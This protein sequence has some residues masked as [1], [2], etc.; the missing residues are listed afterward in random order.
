ML[1]IIPYKLGLNYWVAFASFITFYFFLGM[2]GFYKLALKILKDK[3][4]AILAFVLL[5][6]SSLS[7]RVFDS[8]IMMILTPS[9]WFFYFG[10]VF[11]NSGQRSAFVGMVFCVML[12]L[13]TYVP[14]YFIVLVLSFLI[15]FIPI[16]WKET[17]GFFL[18]LREFVRLQKGLF[19][20]CVVATVLAC[21]PDVLFFKSAGQGIFS[22]PLRHF[23]AA[24][25]HVLIVKPDVTSYWAIPE[26]LMY[27]L[28]YLQDLRLFDFAVLYVPLFAI[29]LLLLG[30]VTSVNPKTFFILLWGLFL[31]A[32][33][34]PYLVG[35]YDFLHK[36]IFFFRYFRNLHFFL[37][38]AIL[39]LFIL[40]VVEQMRLFLKM[41]DDNPNQKS[42]PLIYIIVVHCGIAGFFYWQE[43]FNY[44]TWAVLGLS[45]V[46]F[47]GYLYWRL[48]AWL[49]C[50]FCFLAAVIQPFEVYQSLQRNAF[51]TIELSSYDYF[52]SEFQ[53]TR[54]SKKVL[55]DPAQEY[56][57]R[58]TEKNNPIYFGTQWYN[59]LW[60]NMNSK[61][62]K[63]YTFNK[64]IFYD[65]V[66]T[67][68]EHKQE[69]GLI[70]DA[71]I[72]NLNVAFVPQ[73]TPLQKAQGHI[74]ANPLTIEKS[75]ERLEVTDFN[76]NSVKLRTNLSTKKFLVF[77]DCY[78]PGWRAYINGKETAL[79]RANIAFKG[80]WVPQGNQEIEFVFGRSWG[81]RFEIF[82]LGF[83]FLFFCLMFWLFKKDFKPK[84]GEQ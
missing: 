25:P 40:F 47:I 79:Y 61:I 24:D 38:L 68:D 49:V 65:Y 82:L 39:P 55:T 1:I 32:I 35:L 21:L 52:L 7:T 64:F 72:K 14:F 63:K 83:Y 37:W 2:L 17:T 51:K 27:S 33:G 80:I 53:Y 43:S 45:L 15:F 56:V 34:S 31:L 12:L 20:L 57:Y 71:W 36:F 13:T 77:N 22:M 29:I 9:L 62:I 26:E 16:F 58:P 76:A 69:W 74:A 46:F 48:S 81:Y 66:A 60:N 5:S 44:S 4:L 54:G 50:G 19:L 30:M 11:G 8:Y 70:A 84:G 59:L 42:W 3:K 18:R 6:F 41:L 28:F 67:F 75:D 23:N 10:F 78:Y 73:G